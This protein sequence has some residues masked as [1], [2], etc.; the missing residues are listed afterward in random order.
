MIINPAKDNNIA[1]AAASDKDLKERFLADNQIRVLKISAK[2]LHKKITT[3]DDEWAE[4]MLALS[5]AIDCYDISKGNFWSYAGVVIRNRLFDMY[6]KCT[7]LSNE[8][9]VSPDAFDGNVKEAEPEYSLQNEIQNKTGVIVDHV[10]KDEIDALGKELS[11]F[12]FSFFDLAQCS[13]KTKSTKAGCFE[14]V[15]A[16]FLPPPLVRM[17]MNMKKLPVTAIKNRVKVSGKLLDRHRRYI[18]ASTLILS[19]D[20]PRLSQYMEYLK[21]AINSQSCKDKI[22]RKE[23]LL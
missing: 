5:F 2:I 20:Y 19:G 16:I 7:Y 9:S 13:P 14:A 21:P 6:R 4:A 3:S 8:M 11:S 15:R 10:I 17:I 23:E 1:L 18:I 22:R 12:G